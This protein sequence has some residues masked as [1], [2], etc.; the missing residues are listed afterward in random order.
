MRE[1]SEHTDTLAPAID[2]IADQLCQAVDGDFDFAVQSRAA[3]TRVQKLAMLINFVVDSARRA[4]AEL[5]QEHA[6]L[7]ESEQRH[8]QYITNTPFGVF[9]TD[10]KG[11]F[12]QVN[13]SACRL[14]DYSEAELLAMAI[15]DL[16]LAEDRSTVMAFFQ[17]VRREGHGQLE[18]RFR[19]NHGQQCWLAVSA[20]ALSPSHSIGFCNDITERVLAEQALRE[21]Q[22]VL[23][24]VINALPVRVF[25]KSTALTYLGCNE[26]CAMDAGFSDPR[27]MIG[28]DD[29]AMAWREDAEKYRADDLAVI[30]SGESRLLFEES[31]TTAAGERLHLL[32]SKVPLRDAAGA[33]VGVVGAYYDITPLREAE[34]QKRALEDQ[35]RQSQKLQAVGQLAAGIAHEINTPSQ[36]VGDSVQFLADSQDGLRQLITAYRETLANLSADALSATAAARIADLEAAID[37][38]FLLDNAPS[39]LG[40]ALDGVARISRIVRAMKEFAHPDQA[41]KSPADLNHALETTLTIARNEYKYVADVETEFGEL[42]PVSCHLGDLNQVF[43]NLLVN[44]AHAIGDVVGSS[45]TKGIIRVRTLLDGDWARI[46]IADTGGGIPEPIRERI[47]EPFFTTKPVGKG[48]GQGLAIAHA[49][50]VGKH[51]GELS[52]ETAVGQGTTFIIRLPLVRP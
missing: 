28:K 29:F 19:R 44:A 24:S 14:T 21:S 6:R 23:H 11:R 37:I 31:Q 35:L 51:N 30:A 27:E 9:V 1:L 17:R 41:E 10:A 36:F 32:T 42:P 2:E 52:F 16:L 43:L 47:F 25:W 40:D 33:V 46:E 5:R 4:L 8:R 12:V 7:Q 49:I 34:A 50:V 3:D 26:A 15:E 13:P 48:S 39:A 38:D 20:V 18:H 45:G 22:A